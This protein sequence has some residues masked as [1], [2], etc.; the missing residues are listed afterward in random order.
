[1]PSTSSPN[2]GIIGAP[3]LDSD[4]D[5]AHVPDGTLRACTRAADAL[6]PECT[7][8]GGQFQSVASAA[9]LLTQIGDAGY[10][11]SRHTAVGVAEWLSIAHG[12]NG[13][14]VTVASHRTDDTTAQRC[15]RGRG[16]RR[17]D[18]SHL[19]P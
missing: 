15:R 4:T 7:T 19:N 12:D 16:S 14:G 8:R 9:G 10:A 13:I 2:A 5:C 6:L 11:V 18:G 1:M 17:A 3:G